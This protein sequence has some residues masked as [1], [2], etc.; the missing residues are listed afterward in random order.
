MLSE[1]QKLLS[2]AQEFLISYGLSESEAEHE[3]RLILA[4]LLKCAPLEVYFRSLG[5]EQVSRFW[6]LVKERAKGVPLAYLL[7]EVEFYGYT[8]QIKPGVLIPRPETEILVEETLK[9]A[10]FRGKVL[11][12][13]LGSGCISLTL[14]LERPD[15]LLFGVEISPEA[16]AVAMENRKRYHLEERVLWVRGDWFGPFKPAPFFDMIVSNPPYVSVSEW[17]KLS[18]EVREFEP[19]LALVGGEEGLDFLADTLEKAPFYLKPRGFLLLEIGYRQADKIAEL[20]LRRGYE[21]YFV[22]DLSGIKRVFV[23]KWLAKI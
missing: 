10:P 3:A 17:Q 14:A 19:P 18:K 22:S 6:S 13:G 20:A 15:L 9:L 7:G 16:L 5:E 8:F 12:L 23:G 11:E 1:I 4:H 21:F 2:K